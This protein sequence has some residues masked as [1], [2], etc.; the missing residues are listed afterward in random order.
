MC[1][2]G[3][4]VLKE[5]EFCCNE[6]D[7]IAETARMF[8]V[9]LDKNDPSSIYYERILERPNINWL[10]ILL[11]I[12]IPV[13]FFMEIVKILSKKWE[14]SYSTILASGLL[15]LFYFLLHTKKI[16]ICLIHIYQHFAPDSIRMKC[17][18]E[19][20]CSQYMLLSLEKY[21]VLKGLKMGIRRLKR[22]KV[23]NGGYD[24]P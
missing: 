24:F 13:I 2:Y 7:D 8:L 3:G 19:P 23:G 14:N 1:F 9:N 21:G 5:V 15:L 10:K 6:N 11:Q 22:C 17:R 16:I 20:S 4:F 18:F 12:T